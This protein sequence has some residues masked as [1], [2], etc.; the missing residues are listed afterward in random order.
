MFQIPLIGNAYGLDI[1]TLFRKL[2]AF[3]INGPGWARIEAFNSTEDGR[4]AFQAWANHYNSQGELR[5]CIALAKAKL[6]GIGKR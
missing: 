5:K 1:V 3:L 2:K 4:A 6:K